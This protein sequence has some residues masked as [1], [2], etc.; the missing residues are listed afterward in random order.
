[1]ILSGGLAAGALLAFAALLLT[2]R[3]LRLFSWRAR[4]VRGAGAGAIGCF[5]SL[6]TAWIFTV[7]S[8]STTFPAIWTTGGFRAVGRFTLR[9]AGIFTIGAA[10]GFR[11]DRRIFVHRTGARRGIGA[12]GALGIVVVSGGFAIR[13]TAAITIRGIGWAGAAIFATAAEAFRF[14]AI[15]IETLGT[16]A[17]EIVSAAEI[18]D[19]A[20]SLTAIFLPAL[21]KAIGDITA[22]TLRAI[23]RDIFQPL[24]HPGGAERAVP[25]S[26]DL[27]ASKAEFIARKPRAHRKWIAAGALLAIEIQAIIWHRTS[28]DIADPAILGTAA[29][30][31][32]I[33]EM[34]IGDIS[35]TAEKIAIS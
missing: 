19:G 4:L 10:C 34:D 5:F 16:L 17:V 12:A 15:R 33:A 14:T 3:L 24:A 35:C 11:S 1:M 7:R 21:A 29:D 31:A 26:I 32:L 8:F 18:A 20:L 2:T 9:A 22:E 27:R 23:D 30:D 25:W 6:W 28:A 13:P